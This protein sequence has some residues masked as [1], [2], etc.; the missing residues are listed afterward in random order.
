MAEF[1]KQWRLCHGASLS[2]LAQEPDGP[3]LGTASTVTQCPRR[4]LV[5][6]A[7]ALLFLRGRLGSDT[8]GQARV[9]VSLDD[10]RKILGDAEWITTTPAPSNLFEMVHEYETSTNRRIKSIGD[11]RNMWTRVLGTPENLRG[12]EQLL[13]LV[14]LIFRAAAGQV[15]GMTHSKSVVLKEMKMLDVDIELDVEN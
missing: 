13:D 12:E 6:L 2:E 10:V 5:E 3:G 11:E 9:E 7:P 1:W 4:G 8:M 14:V 15:P